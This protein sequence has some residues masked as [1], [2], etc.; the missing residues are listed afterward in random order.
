MSTGVFPSSAAEF[1]ER[2]VTEQAC[3]DFLFAQRWPDGWRCR[4]CAA[5]VGWCNRRGLIECGACGYQASLTAGTV[6]HRSRK[7]LR[8]WFK[9]ILLMVTQKNGVSAR[10]LQSML[11]LSYPTAWTW[12]HKLRLV[13]AGRPRDGLAGVVEADE[14]YVGGHRAGQRGRRQGGGNKSLVV[15]S[16]E[17]RHGAMGR[18]RLQAVPDHGRQ[19]LAGTVRRQVREGSVV[20]TDGL[21]GYTP[22]AAAGYVHRPEAIGKDRAR[23]VTLLPRVHHVISLLRRW[24]LGTHQGAVRAK[25]LPGYLAEFEFRFNRRRAAHRTL[26]FESLIA[27]AVG[28]PATTYRGLVAPAPAYQM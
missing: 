23:A 18:L 24:L 19:S 15:V 17:E 7:P 14:A 26:L 25:H 6:F 5:A 9:A 28:A 21:D 1:E 11:G 22:L 4:R 3:R 10:S 8:L 2:F 16:V 12:L 20:R 27:L 13:M